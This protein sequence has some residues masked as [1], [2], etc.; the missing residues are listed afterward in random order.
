MEKTL[1]KIENTIHELVCLLD[2]M[3]KGIIYFQDN[4]Q[5]HLLNELIESSPLII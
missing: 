2:V 4:N 1:K 5:L 3:F